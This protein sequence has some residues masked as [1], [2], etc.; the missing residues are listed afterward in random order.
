MMPRSLDN[1]EFPLLEDSPDAALL[2]WLVRGGS[3]RQ[4]LL[5]AI[6]LWVWLRS[7]YGDESE[8]V[9]LREPFTYKDWRDAFFTPTHPKADTIPTPHDATC[10][11]AKTAAQWLFTPQTGVSES[12]W[13]TMIQQYSAI[14]DT[15]LDVILQTRLFAVT[16]RS[17]AN[18]L[19]LLR[20]LGW[21]QSV[22]NA[23]CRVAE[24]PD[25][26]A[27][28]SVPDESGL[29]GYDLGF[30]NAHLEAIAQELSQPI[31]EEQRFF[32]EVDYIIAQTQQTVEAWLEALK[33]IWAKQDVPPV[34]LSYGSAR[35]GTVQ[36]VVY[37][38]CVYYVQRAIYLCAM[39]ET[40]TAAG[41]WYNYRLDKIQAM[42]C[43]QWSEP[44]LPLVLQQRRGTLPTPHYIRRQ[45]DQAWGFDFYLKPRLMLLRFQREF[46]DRYIQ[47]TFR[48]K[49]FHKI[50]YEQAY[51][52]IQDTAASSHPS[53]L[54]VIQSRSVDDAYYTVQ[55][56]DG[57]T[58]VG[59]RLRSW[60]PK[61]EVLLPWALRQKQLEE[62]QAEWQLYQ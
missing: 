22:E 61:V 23:Y 44:N 4:N 30:L 45:M 14:A 43:C 15:A 32:L 41:N 37:P 21:L 52:L 57:D 5:K 11:C 2:H 7:L 60:R 34:R 13:W 53:L 9:C 33:I 42:E 58:N 24:F 12:G 29:G 10:A 28:P 35:Y 3:L 62:M 20:E 27:S 1:R 50:T 18:D 39:G 17:L 36:C 26:P 48:H 59:L 25:R 54:Q 8:R 47:G 51:Q 40:P 16:R 6:R 55:Y 46:H 38:V 49:T 19:E 56:R 31:A